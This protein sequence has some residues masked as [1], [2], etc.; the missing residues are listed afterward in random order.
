MNFET[1]VI[2]V[3]SPSMGACAEA[4]PVTSAATSRASARI[5]SRF[6]DLL[7]GGMRSRRPAPR[8]LDGATPAGVALGAGH[9]IHGRREAAVDC[10]TLGDGVERAPQAAA[11]AGQV[12]GAER[13]RLD[14]GRTRHGGV[15][16]VGL[17]LAQEVVGSGTA[18]DLHLAQT[19]L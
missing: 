3:S 6:I 13:R 9:G 5:P 18:V 19:R 12:G 17:E 7:L 2:S 15:E 10:V 8:A 1:G 14:D 4:P 11:E 16:H